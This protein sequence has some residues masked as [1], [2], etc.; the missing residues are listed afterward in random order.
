ML[1]CSGSPVRPVNCCDPVEAWHHSAQ[2]EGARVN[3]AQ[4]VGL[5]RVAEAWHECDTSRLHARLV[6]ATLAR[7]ARGPRHQN[8]TRV[9]RS[10]SV[11]VVVICVLVIVCDCLC[12]FCQRLDI[13]TTLAKPA[14]KRERTTPDL[15]A[16]VLI[17]FPERRERLSLHQTYVF[18]VSTLPQAER[19]LTADVR[20][21]RQTAGRKSRHYI[22]NHGTHYLVSIYSKPA[23]FSIS[24]LSPTWAALDSFSFDIREPADKWLVL[25]VKRDVQRLRNT[26]QQHNAAQFIVCVRSLKTGALI[27]PEE[28]GFVREGRA[29]NEHALLVVFLTDAAAEDRAGGELSS[30]NT[31][32]KALQ[33]DYHAT[34]RN[35]PNGDAATPSERRRRD[36]SSGSKS[37]N[38]RTRSRTN[39]GS[40][41]RRRRKCR[42]RPLYV[43]FAEL[44]WS[45]WVI[46]PDGYDAYHCD[47]S[48]D[49]PLSDHYKPTNH[50]VVQTIVNSVRPSLAPKVCCIPNRLSSIS[51]LY[52]DP[53]GGLVY[54]QYTDMVVERCGC[55]WSLLVIRTAC[56][57]V[58]V[59][60]FTTE[61]LG[62]RQAPLGAAAHEGSDVLTCRLRG[63]RWQ[64]NLHVPLFC[65][66][67]TCTRSLRRSVSSALVSLSTKGPL[68]VNVELKPM[69]F[70]YSN[71]GWLFI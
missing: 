59:C 13:S 70:S 8:C 19:I 49:F 12:L 4:S 57:S 64:P 69:R 62:G 68:Y 31:A 35:A 45:N 55:S 58:A 60:A 47:G 48:C 33:K 50:A 36:S 18:A 39:R 71:E 27:S 37:S 44:G 51:M 42:R 56:G 10:R 2:E 63:A 66:L 3:P 15:S 23:N 30:M 5:V 38:S 1:V 29:G 40:R 26:G 67:N 53:E 52:T 41:T 11:A 61:P 6:W 7:R 21:L 34:G 46:A 54:K 32:S 24:M 20:I 9:H 22:E 28:V 43:D 25:S 65:E 14:D 17:L 16:T